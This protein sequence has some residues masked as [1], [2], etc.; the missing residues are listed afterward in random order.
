MGNGLVD[1]MVVVMVVKAA[2]D[3]VVMDVA[4]TKL[5]RATSMVGRMLERFEGVPLQ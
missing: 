3:L 5:K 2:N 4:A 1:L